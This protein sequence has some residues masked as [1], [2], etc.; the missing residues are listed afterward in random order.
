M[1]LASWTQTFILGVRG[2]LVKDWK[3]EGRRGGKNAKAG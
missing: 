3:V 2:V 1:P